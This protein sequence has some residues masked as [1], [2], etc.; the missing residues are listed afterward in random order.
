M[1]KH[2]VLGDKAYGCRRGNSRFWQSRRSLMEK[3]IA[4][5]QSVRAWLKPKTL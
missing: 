1:A 5:P 3:I 2:M 4:H